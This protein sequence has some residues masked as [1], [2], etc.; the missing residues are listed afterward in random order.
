MVVKCWRCLDILPNYFFILKVLS[1]KLKKSFTLAEV[2]ITL[3]I[4][5]VV[6]AITIPTLMNRYEATQLRSAFLSANSIVKS[7]TGTM[8]SAGDHFDEISAQEIS[9]YFKASEFK[10]NVSNPYYNFHGTMKSSGAQAT[11]MISEFKFQNGMTALV[12]KTNPS[13]SG[14]KKATKNLLAIDINGKDNKPNRYGH[15]VYFW[16]H[17]DISEQIEIIG[18]V[19]S[20]EEFGFYQTICQVEKVNTA[21]SENVIGC[22]ARALVEQKWFENLKNQKYT[23]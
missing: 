16:Y 1:K 12:F 23:K 6:S 11:S 3:T 14:A 8:N 21:Q 18:S 19:N 10:S 20:K 5:G 15:D 13:Y 22:G 7:V 2:L 9:K 17:S 4:I